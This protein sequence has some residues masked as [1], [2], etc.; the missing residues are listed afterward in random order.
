MKTESKPPLSKYMPYTL[1]YSTSDTTHLSNS[2]V[3]PLQERME[4]VILNAELF[5]LFES[6][7]AI[8]KAIM[9]TQS[10]HKG[11]KEEGNRQIKT[12]IFKKLS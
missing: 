5:K 10:K 7:K 12:F 8:M 9:Q 6:F 2:H 11:R 4:Q 3:H 1:H